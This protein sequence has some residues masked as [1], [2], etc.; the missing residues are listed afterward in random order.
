M[1]DKA[2]RKKKR[3]SALAI[4]PEAAATQNAIANALAGRDPYST[5]SQVVGTQNAIANALS[6][7]HAPV[8][9]SAPLKSNELRP[10]P[11]IVGAGASPISPLQR[12]NADVISRPADLGHL[13]RTA[14]KASGL[15]QQAFADL[16]GVGRRF[17]S[18]LESGKTTLEFGKVL[19]CCAAAGIDLFA[20]R[21][22]V[23]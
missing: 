19:R 23:A 7:G 21:R 20:A 2:P 10:R 15:N 17:V 13:V 3:P 12:D 4:A 18:E 6:A 5:T 9:R 1:K 16:A 14:R 11:A 8:T 22:H